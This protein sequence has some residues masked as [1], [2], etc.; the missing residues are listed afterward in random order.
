MDVFEALVGE[1]HPRRR[2]REIQEA[3]VREAE[4]NALREQIMKEKREKAR[5]FN[6]RR[7]ELKED[8]EL[9]KIVPNS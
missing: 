4:E 1:V 5:A 8:K 2:W 6:A 3:Q 7:L 9:P